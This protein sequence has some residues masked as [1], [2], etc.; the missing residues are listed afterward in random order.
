MGH[1]SAPAPPLGAQSP[2]SLGPAWTPARSLLLGGGGGYGPH[3]GVKSSMYI[4]CVPGRA[5]HGAAC[6]LPL[7]SL[8]LAPASLH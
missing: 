3:G 5:G 6:G 1:T 7:Q 8:T 4:S 2:G